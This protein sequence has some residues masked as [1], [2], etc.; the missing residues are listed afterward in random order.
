MPTFEG[1]L[2]WR[3][4]AV[5]G[6]FKP[7][8]ENIKKFAHVYPLSQA[9]NPPANQFVDVSNQDFSTIAPADYKFWEY[10]NLVVQGEPVESLDPITLGYFASIGI[11]KGKPFAPDARMK[12]ILTEAAA[13]GDAT[14]RSLTFRMRAKDNYYYENS[15]WCIPFSGGYKFECQPGVRNLDAFSS[16]AEISY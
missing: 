3:N 6:D 9:A 1:F 8:I 15:A 12:K 13:V 4:F 16:C 2:G 11:E 14:A 10:L 5:N 7:A